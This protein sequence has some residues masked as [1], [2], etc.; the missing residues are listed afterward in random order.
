MIPFNP[1]DL[2]AIQPEL[3][4]LGATCAILLIDL[5][6][7][8]SQ[9]DITHWLSIAT[10]A[11]TSYLVWR[12]APE[13]SS[14]VTAF[15]GMLLHDGISVVLKQFIL[16][17]SGLS[18]FYARNYM[19]ERSLLVG[20]LYLLV[21]FA[22]LGMMLLVS[23]GSLITVYLGLELLALSS[24][25]LVAMNRDSASSAE[26]AI[27]YF[28]LGALA[29]GL[30]LYGMSM[31]YGATGSLDLATITGKFGQVEHPGW[32][33]FGLVF[34]VCG[35][36]FKV[37]AA[38]FHMW[39]PDV[40]HGA[41]TAVTVF[42]GSAPKIAAFGLA[43]RLLEG[44]LGPLS[45]QWTLMLAI[46]AVAS[47]AVGNVLAIAQS[48]LKRMLAYSTISHVGFMLL[49]F[50]GGTPAGYSAAMFYIIS[51]TMTATVAFGMIAL[52]ARKGFECEEIDDFKGLNQR[53]PW[54][55]AI[56]GIA[57]FSLA[58]VPPLFGFFAK[59]LVL[60]A[61]ID[62]GFLWLAIVAIV[63][64]IIG[65]YYYLRVVK[66][67]YFD[68]AAEETALPLPSDV[69]LRWVI[70]INGLALIVLG[71]AWGPLFDWCNRAFGV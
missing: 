39:L 8:P 63:F 1:A 7:K 65:I 61:A 14:G 35:I 49:G 29:S 36:A 50:V 54:Y 20:E 43:Y 62:A 17:T 13:L 30:L 46:L 5:F 3:V 69:A 9:R 70:S 6:I 40:Y 66:V 12:G 10:L 18:L 68:A 32:L 19:R 57:M 67:M 11:L 51:Y 55:A 60:K 71:L 21:L 24:Y 44:G 58:G 31:I 23:A 27:K 33:A 47:L 2:I 41:P 42:I 48:N 25:A 34:L 16:L 15:N 53:S 22:T 26:A 28:V 37:G 38:P 52:L 64:A 45:G 4:L 59:L 56:M